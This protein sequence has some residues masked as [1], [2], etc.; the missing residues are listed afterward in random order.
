ME[1]G[2]FRV[3]IIAQEHIPIPAIGNNHIIALIVQMP[4][5]PLLALA[6][7]DH[8]P[9]IISSKYFIREG[10]NQLNH[11]ILDLID[12]PQELGIGFVLDGE[13]GLALFELL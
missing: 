4:N 1:V 12:D 11:A 6:L 10:T 13:L 7:P 9:L 2:P 3:G 8:N 5:L